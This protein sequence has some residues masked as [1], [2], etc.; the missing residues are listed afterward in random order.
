MNK[1]F[2][3][4][5]MSIEMMDETEIESVMSLI[6]EASFKRISVGVPCQNKEGKIFSVVGIFNPNE[7]NH[8]Y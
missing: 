3:D 1:V 2:T 7:S 5:L 8:N 4:S 6:P